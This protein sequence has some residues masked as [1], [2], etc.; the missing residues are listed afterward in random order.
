MAGGWRAA[1]TIKNNPYS[2]SYNGVVLLPYLLLVRGSLQTLE[3]QGSRTD[4]YSVP[5]HEYGRLIEARQ[6][7]VM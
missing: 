1:C 7:N 4:P 6:A 3:R 2:Y 5:Q